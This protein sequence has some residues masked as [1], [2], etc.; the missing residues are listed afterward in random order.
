MVIALTIRFVVMVVGERGLEMTEKKPKS[1][2]ECWDMFA[3]KYPNDAKVIQT[4]SRYSYVYRPS[5]Q[6]WVKYQEENLRK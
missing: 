1:L 4:K 5:W 6:K 3:K 2:E